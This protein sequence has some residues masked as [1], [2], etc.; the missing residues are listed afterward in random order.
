MLVEICG[1]TD[2]SSR[3]EE[4]TATVINNT[5]E[6][7]QTADSAHEV[8][9]LARDGSSVSA[10]IQEIFENAEKVHE[11]TSV[12]ESITFQTNILAL[13][14]AVEAAWGQVKRGTVLQW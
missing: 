7:Q 6:A 14:A 10:T 12:I 5:V 8:V 4:Q 3:A 1:N 11:I 2:L 13:N 9:Q